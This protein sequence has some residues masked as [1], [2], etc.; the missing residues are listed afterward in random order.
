[1]CCRCPDLVTIPYEFDAYQQVSE[2]VYGILLQHSSVVQPL[3]C[4][5]AYLDASDCTDPLAVAQQIRRQIAETGCTASIG[6]GPSLLV[7]RIATKKAKPD[8]LFRILPQVW[9]ALL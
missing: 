2:A 7:S 8:G 4:D 9:G 1:M 6:I 5:E 3:S